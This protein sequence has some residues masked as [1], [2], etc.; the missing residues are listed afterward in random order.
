[1]KDERKFKHLVFLIDG[2]WSSAARGTFKDTTN[3]SRLNHAIDTEDDDGNPQVTYYIPGL[4][5]RGW[6][7]K[8]S[9]GALGAG[10]DEIIK[11]TYIN[12]ASNY[13]EEDSTHQA[14]R[15]YLFGFSRGA[16]VARAVAGLI[17]RCGLLYPRCI[18]RFWRVWS[19]YL[20]PQSD[21][22]FGVEI[23]EWINQNVRIEMLGVFDTVLGRRYNAANLVSELRFKDFKFDSSIKTGVQVLSIDDNRRRYSPIIWD[24]IVDGVYSLPN[25]HQN[26]LAQI[27]LPGVHADIGGIILQNDNTSGFL[28]IVAFLTMVEQIQGY[29]SLS[30]DD[31]YISRVAEGLKYFGQIRVSNERESSYMKALGYR[32]RKTGRETIGSNIDIGEKIHPI[33]DM[34]RGREIYVRGK[35][36]PYTNDSIDRYKDEIERCRS[37]FQTLYTEECDRIINQ[38]K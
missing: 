16:V 5:T 36:A 10:L 13:D 28:S 21:P 27:W 2:T 11:E 24:G 6:I 23:S 37:K 17:S 34:L 1:M 15:I 4:G 32:V 19:Y 9:G 22:S 14:D 29:T 26:T 12:I 33:Y 25:G 31:D 8:A 35:K 38:L 7:D 18:D 20:N 30:L 3:V